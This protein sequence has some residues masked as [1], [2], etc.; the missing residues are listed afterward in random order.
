MSS[1]GGRD[2]A[3]AGDTAVRPDRRS[4]SGSTD[5]ARFRRRRIAA[6]GV[7]ALLVLAALGWGAWWALGRFGPGVREVTVTG[8]RAIA[9][10]DV[11]AA[12]GV[13][14][15]A[16]LAAVDTDG[17][18]ARVAGI[19]GVADVDVSRSW[20]HTLDI[21]VAERMPVALVD[22]PDGTRLVDATGLAYRTLPAQP[23]C[24]P[25]PA[26]APGCPPPRLPT[27]ALP[28]VAPGD[29]VT[30]AALAVVEALPPEIR[31]QVDAVQLGPGGHTLELA[32]TEGRRV[33]WGRWAESDGPTTARR[34]AVL[35]PL[36]TREGS[37][38]DVS[39]ADLPT[40]RE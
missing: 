34:A 3:R 25:L 1:G 39:S 32:L 18:A 20:P 27:L 22:A 21:T 40:V 37:V 23:Q 31:D 4:P 8:V 19:P 33:L 26:G 5:R 28:R 13:P 11:R 14:D 24:P 12:A 2:A 38:Y 36:L 9:G 29:P 15:G 30:A 10:N 7:V 17:V 35:G 6:G 16:P